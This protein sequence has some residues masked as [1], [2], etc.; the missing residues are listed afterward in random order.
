[1]QTAYVAF[2]FYSVTRLKGTFSKTME[3][4]LKSNFAVK[5]VCAVL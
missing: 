4:Y 3:P 1:M 2:F 5:I